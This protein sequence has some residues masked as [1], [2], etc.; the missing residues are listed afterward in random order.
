MWIIF[1]VLPE[2]QVRESIGNDLISIAPYDDPRVKE[3]IS[4]SPYAKA[5][6]ENFKD[7]FGRSIV[8]SFLIVADTIPDRVRDIEAIVGFRNAFALSVITRGHEHSL[9]SQ[10]VAYPLYSDYFQLYPITISRDNNGFL[11]QSPSLLGFD[12]EYEKFA[13]QTNPSLAGPRGIFTD[14]D[15]SL[16]GLILR[17]WER[18]FLKGKISDWAT[19]ALFRSLEMAYRAS[20]MPF[21][22]HA[23]VNDYG[24]SASLWVSA[25]E[26]LSHPRQG[27]ADLLSVLNMLS[28]FPWKNKM[29]KRRLYKVKYQRKEYRV[30]L[31]QRLYKE[32]Y[33]TRNEF[34]HGNPLTSNRLHPFRQKNRP[35]ITKFAPLL[36][37]VALLCY[38]EKYRDK[39]KDRNGRKRYIDEYLNE[40]SLSEAILKSVE[41]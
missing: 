15:T 12:D 14:A 30:N 36:Y 23:T 26:I 24:T 34:L 11:T 7:Q 29:V 28:Q 33:D 16:F 18:R 22:N 27:K 19:T 9:S 17:A 8:P 2:I 3:C 5:L 38:L 20:S 4:N 25:L 21:A 41:Q 31:P 32:L 39:R 35:S 13:G 10:F 40:E 37:K 6:G 1:F